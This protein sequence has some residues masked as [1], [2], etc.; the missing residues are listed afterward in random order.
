MAELSFYK[1]KD[2]VTNL[3]KNKL[4]ETII[5]IISPILTKQESST[6]YFIKLSMYLHFTGQFHE[7][8]AEI[9]FQAQWKTV[10]SFVQCFGKAIFETSW[11]WAVHLSG[12]M[13]KFRLF[14][15]LINSPFHHGPICCYV[16]IY[17]CKS[18]LWFLLRDCFVQFVSETENEA[19]LNTPLRGFSVI[20]TWYSKTH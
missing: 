8:S 5:P 11:N 6:K 4:N 9:I 18:S 1:L 10:F 20:N 14:R 13:A 19:L 17:N 12:C 16:K 15:E 7:N 2:H 3:Q